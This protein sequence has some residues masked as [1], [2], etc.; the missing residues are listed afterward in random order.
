MLRLVRTNM[1]I[2]FPKGYPSIWKANKTMTIVY[3][4]ELRWI[5]LKNYC[6]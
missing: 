4:E 6:N 1:N 3:I 5:K 2:E